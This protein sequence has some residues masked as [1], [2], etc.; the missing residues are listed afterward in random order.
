MQ[1]LLCGLSVCVCVCVRAYVCVCVRLCACVRAYVCV[2][3][4][5]CLCVWSVC[6]LR[7]CLYVRVHARARACADV[8]VP[9][10]AQYLTY[11]TGREGERSI[12]LRCRPRCSRPG[13]VRRISP[14]EKKANTA[15]TPMQAQQSKK[16]QLQGP[17]P[18]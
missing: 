9:V 6:G 16:L 4:C 14:S 3:P 8:C 1:V 2:C 15:V 13:G 10:C 18:A 12:G 11:S 5:V 17:E 7:L